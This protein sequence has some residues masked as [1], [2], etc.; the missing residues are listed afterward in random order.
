MLWTLILLADQEPARDTT[1]QGLFGMLPI[2]LIG[3]LAY[4]ML[5][6]PLKKQEQER[7]TLA[8]NLKKNDKV[9]TSG[10]MYGT[11]VNISETD[12]EVTLRVD[13]N[14]RVKFTKASIVRNLTNEDAARAQKAAKE[15]KG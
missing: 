14:T 13:D 3:L 5:I 9:L 8:S 6:R 12:D 15:G 2:L 10:G 1:G 4:F 7:Q 11:V